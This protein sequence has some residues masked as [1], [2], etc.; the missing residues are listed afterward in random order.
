MNLWL[1]KRT[2]EDTGYDEFLGFVVA[3]ESEE[4]CRA[5]VSESSYGDEGKATWLDPSQ[6]RATQIGTAAQAE[7]RIILDSFQAG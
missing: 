3:A 6:S 4:R 1:L 7:E 2:T 5:L